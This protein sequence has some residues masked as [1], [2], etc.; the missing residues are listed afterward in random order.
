MQIQRYGE[1]D[2]LKPFIALTKLLGVILCTQGCCKHTVILTG[3]TVLICVGNF[4]DLK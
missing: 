2:A 3:V 4:Q 1:A